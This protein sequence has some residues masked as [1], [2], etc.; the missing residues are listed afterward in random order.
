MRP[1]I[2]IHNWAMAAASEK[3]QGNGKKGKI[4]GFFTYSMHWRNLNA[5]F[6][7]AELCLPFKIYLFKRWN[8]KEGAKEREIFLPLIHSHILWQ[9]LGLLQ[10]QL[11]SKELHPGLPRD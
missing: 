8:R 10:A 2:F 6:C 5:D 4:C 1:D 11:S 7:F 3:G 9:Q